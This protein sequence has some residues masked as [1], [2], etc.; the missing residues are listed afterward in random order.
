VRVLVEYLSEAGLC[1]D[2]ATTLGAGGLFIES[3]QPLPKGTPIKLRFSLPGSGVDH[4]IEGAVAWAHLPSD[5]GSGSPG[6]GIEF[7]D[8]VATKKLAREL[9]S[10]DD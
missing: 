2:T 4:E 3:D 6:M 5:G 1:H 10:L 9:E 8:R 7:R